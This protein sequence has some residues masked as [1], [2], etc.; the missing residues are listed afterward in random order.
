MGI[1]RFSATTASF[2]TT[3]PFLGNR[4]LLG[5]MGCIIHIPRHLLFV[6]TR[7]NNFLF[8]SRFEV[9]AVKGMGKV[10]RTK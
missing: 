10:S 2:P 8:S 6:P 9:V 3:S 5:R 7:V 1:N 4:L